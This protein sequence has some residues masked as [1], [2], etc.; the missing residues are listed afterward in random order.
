MHRTSTTKRNWRCCIHQLRIQ[1]ARKDRERERER[2]CRYYKSLGLTPGVYAHP[3]LPVRSVCPSV[4]HHHPGSLAADQAAA[5]PHASI[6]GS[7][8]RELR[9][10]LNTPCNQ[11]TD[12]P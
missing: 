1:G 11:R 6:T 8:Q 9:E 2:E 10:I 5:A 7:R 4:M 12:N 3:A